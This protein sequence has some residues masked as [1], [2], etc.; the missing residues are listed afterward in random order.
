MKK[1]TKIGNFFKRVII[2]LVVIFCALTVLGV[3]AKF[4]G[5]ISNEDIKHLSIKTIYK[6]IGTEPQ[7]DSH[8]NI[9][10]LLVWVGGTWHNWWY[11]A[12]SIIVASFDTK[13]SSVSMLS[14]PRDLYVSTQG[15]SSKINALFARWYGKWGHSIASWAMFLKDKVEEIAGLTIPYYAVIDFKGFEQFIDAIGGINI[16]VPETIYDKLYPVSEEWD[17][18]YGTFYLQEWPQTLDGATALKY[19]RSRHSTSDFSRSLRQQQLIHAIKEKILARGISVKKIQTYYDLYKDMVHTNLSLQEMLGMY[20]YL[21]DAT[22]AINMFGLNVNCSYKSFERTHAG[23]FLYYPDRE[24]FGGASVILPMWATPSNLSFYRYIT[25]FGRVIF[26]N[27]KHLT[28]GA[29]IVVKNAIDKSFARKH[30]LLASWWARKVAVKLKKFW[31]TVDAIANAEMKLW[32]TTIVLPSTGGVNYSGTVEILQSF[33]PIGDVVYAT[34]TWTQLEVILGNDFVQY[35]VN[36]G[37]D[38]NTLRVPH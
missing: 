25:N 5:Y 29:H 20:K 31:F 8:N 14:I 9:N 22:I 12:D 38:F 32:T 26:D 35:V 11:L 3:A 19:A 33:F 1:K 27:Q 10:I 15:V 2:M 34:G 21:E 18:R 30:K 24:Q 16:D 36:S 37:F 4:L 7:K 28:E 23:C 13:H 6:T 17:G